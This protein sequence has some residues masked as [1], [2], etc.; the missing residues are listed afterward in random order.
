MPT[1]PEELDVLKP[2]ANDGSSATS[3]SLLVGLQANEPGA[4]RRLDA[5]YGPV[6]DYWC[7][8]ANLQEA[9]LADIRQEVGLTV[10]LRIADFRRKPAV[11]AFRGW[12]RAIA[13]SK[14][15]DLLRRQKAQRAV[16]AG[17]AG[18]DEVPAPFPEEP[19]EDGATIEAQLLYRRA[20]DLIRQ[21]FEEPTWRAFLAVVVDGRTAKD[22]ARDLEMTNQAV[23]SAKAR[24][25]RRLREEFAEVLD[26]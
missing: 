15:V 6:I 22:V 17:E 9:D 11:G 5:L 1:G 16:P 20:L 23:H 21:D 25:L 12:L 10:I 13:R 3:L 4:W 8:L 14:I 7:R 18:L 26:T 19:D 2:T 24:V